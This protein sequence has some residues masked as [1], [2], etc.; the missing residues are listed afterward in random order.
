MPN[1]LR[2]CGDGPDELSDR[3]DPGAERSGDRLRNGAVDGDFARATDHLFIIIYFRVAR[4]VWLR[5][6]ETVQGGLN[7]SLYFR[8]R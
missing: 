8:K 3:R 5:F 1:V 2:R 7:R 4:R 6:R